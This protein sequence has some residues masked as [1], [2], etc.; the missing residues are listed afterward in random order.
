MPD[1]PELPAFERPVPVCPVRGSVLFPTMVMPIDAGRPISIRAINAALDRDRSIVIVSQ[2]D[3]EVEEPRRRRPL[4]TGTAC[5][6]MRMKKNP[7]G[8]IQMLVRAVARV[9]IER[10]TTDAGVIEAQVRP[11]DV[12]CRRRVLLQAAFR[13]L[14]EKFGELVEAGHRG[15]QAEVAQFVLNLEDPG[16]FADYVAYHLDFRVGDKQAVLEAAE[17][18]RAPPQGAGAHRHRDRAAGDPAPAAARG[19]GR[20]RPQPA[21]VLPARADQGAPEG[22][23]RLRRGGGRGRGVPREARGARAAR[24]RHEG[25]AA[26]AEPPRPHAPRLGRGVGHPHL[27]HHHH[28]AALERPLRGQA[29]HG[30]RR[31]GPRGGPLRPREGQGPG[32]RVP[33][34]AQA[35]AGPRPEGRARRRRGQPRPD[36]AVRRP[37]RRR[38]DVDRQVDRQGARPRVRAHQPRRRARRVRHPRPP[39]HL[40][41]QHARAHHPGHPPGGH[42]EP[43]VPARRGRQ[44]RRVVPGRPS[45]ALLEVLDPAQN[46]TF[47]DHYLGCR[48]TSPRCCS[49]RRRTTRS[50]SPTR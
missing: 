33:R 47:V 7:D 50:R 42:Q 10:F 45:S 9:A 35:Q 27:P 34:R 20:D 38:Q 6:I 39:A 23:L 48:S 14:K 15:L 3:R 30:G 2:R 11:L 28:R 41:R 44:A 12:P 40:H 19:Q 21:R 29:R 16:Q 32:A 43:G 26:R 18:R 13:E 22:A 17:R 8:S 37:A 25:G 46:N 24:G 5:H 49:S 1:T 31:R 4:R 36:P